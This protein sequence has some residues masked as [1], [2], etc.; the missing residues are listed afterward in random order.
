MRKA[1]SF[2]G[3]LVMPENR[4]ARLAVQELAAAVV[5]GRKAEPGLL[6]LHG[7]PGT[8]KSHL[9][10]ALIGEVTRRGGGTTVRVLA[11]P[12]LDLLDTASPHVSPFSGPQT[13]DHDLLVV[14][15]LQHLSARG[16]EPLV[17]ALDQCAARDVPVVCTTAESPRQLGERLPAR[18]VSRLVCGLVVSLQTWTPPSRLLFLH[19]MAQRRQLAIAPEALVWVADNLTGAGRVL[20]GAL[21]RLEAMAQCQPRVL[22][23]ATVAALLR[24]DVQ[25][26]QPTLERIAH[27]VSRFF[28]VEPRHIQSQRRHRN[29]LWPRQVGMYLARRLTGLSLE[30]IG[31]YFGGRDHSTVLHACRKVERAIR[32]DEVVAGAMHQLNADLAR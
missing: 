27:G 24:G 14:E 11:A 22:D 12:D 8:G 32:Q 21:A 17:Q 3:F 1:K 28:R 30:R 10:S 2:A 13:G 23:A 20:E 16:V 6:L 9:V 4:S 29:I 31:A 18:L 15:D 19:E 7:L 5:A 25:A 26:G